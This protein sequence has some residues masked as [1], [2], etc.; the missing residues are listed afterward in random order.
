[1]VHHGR[2]GPGVSR[3]RPPEA[4]AHVGA[5]QQEPH[6]GAGAGAVQ[7]RFRARLHALG[8]AAAALPRRGNGGHQ[9]QRLPPRFARPQRARDPRHA[10]RPGAP[11]RL[12]LAPG[13]HLRL[14]GRRR[15]HQ[16]LCRPELLFLP[17]RGGGVGAEALPA[18]AAADQGGRRGAHLAARALPARPRGGARLRAGLRLLQLRGRQGQRRPGLAGGGHAHVRGRHCR[19]DAVGQQGADEV[20]LRH[21]HGR[22]RGRGRG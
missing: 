22:G 1:M 19:L 5:L 8:L 10:R 6:R 4:R 14:R 20:R 11:R 13:R 16:Q 15:E 12:R 17:G 18:A 7:L 2:E 9:R 21:L 3:G